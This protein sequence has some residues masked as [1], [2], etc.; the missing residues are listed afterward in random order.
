[1]GGDNVEII[2]NPFL[3]NG[4]GLAQSMLKLDGW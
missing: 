2:V 1:M 3:L 4:R